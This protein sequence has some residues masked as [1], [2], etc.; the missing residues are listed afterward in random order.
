[1]CQGTAGFPT[2]RIGVIASQLL[3]QNVITSLT[4]DWLIHPT[5]RSGFDGL[6]QTFTVTDLPSLCILTR[7]VIETYLALFYLAVQPTTP[8][9]REFR[10]MWWDWHEVNE[11]I[12]SL[13]R[14]GSKAAKLKTYGERR[15]ELRSRI[16]KHPNYSSLPPKLKKQF[17]RQQPPTDAVV[18]SKVEIAELA[19]LHSDQ[20]RVVYKSLSQYSH[21][22][23]VAVATM[24]GLSTSDERIRI[25]LR[26]A[27]RH[28][29]SYLLFSVRDFIT[30]FPPGRPLTDE[31][32][33]QLVAIRTAV[34][35]ADLAK[36]E[37]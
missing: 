21:A 26:L 8:A 31:H 33:W 1:M 30:F 7:G 36:V 12:W 14:I 4:I 10:L 17:E 22:Q 3:A 37:L 20:F 27:T 15:N 29:T 13:N 16:A 18:L 25:H 23:P 32:F 24:L 5:P 34:H 35:K 28:A 19:G 9:E 11:R 2:N 6:P